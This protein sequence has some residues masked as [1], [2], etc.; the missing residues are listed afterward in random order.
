[1]ATMCTRQLWPD[2]CAPH[3]SCISVGKWSPH[4]VRRRSIPSA[5]WSIKHIYGSLVQCSQAAELLYFVLT[6]S[7]MKAIT[8]RLVSKAFHGVGGVLLI[9]SC[10]LL[11][12]CSKYAFSL[13]LMNG[14]VAGR[15]VHSTTYIFL[16]WYLWAVIS[17]VNKN[18][19]FTYICNCEYAG[20]CSKHIK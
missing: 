4:H 20:N 11:I 15:L 3:R 17:S 12:S 6:E 14:C 16:S 7:N 18:H 1:M 13:S 19:N 10:M 2:S 5:K 8:G 9:V